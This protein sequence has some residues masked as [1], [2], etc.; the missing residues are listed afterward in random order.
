MRATGA[1]YW[2]GAHDGSKRETGV[3]VRW[4]KGG[5]WGVGEVQGMLD[6]EEEDSQCCGECGRVKETGRGGQK[7]RRVVMALGVGE[8]VRL[9][10]DENTT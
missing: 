8:S 4:L 7:R 10:G 5:S 6:D 3:A 1:K 9:R 2:I